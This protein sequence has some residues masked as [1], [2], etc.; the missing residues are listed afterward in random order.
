[1][2]LTLYRSP[3]KIAAMDEFNV[4]LPKGK[5]GDYHVSSNSGLGAV[6]PK[7]WIQYCMKFWNGK[8]I[9]EKEAYRKP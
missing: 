5:S 3:G 1:M 9:E 6:R 4:P 8:F 2:A 7:G